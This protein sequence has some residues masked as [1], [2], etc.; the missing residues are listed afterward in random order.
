MVEDHQTSWLTLHNTFAGRVRRGVF[1]LL[2]LTAVAVI[3]GF[4]HIQHQKE[5]YLVAREFSILLEK[6]G[7]PKET[8]EQLHAKKA[9]DR[10]TEPGHSSWSISVPL[11][12]IPKVRTDYKIFLQQNHPDRALRRSSCTWER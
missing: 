4:S 11:Q 2:V 12:R 9:T 7:I 3:D 6:S 8:A 1:L 5:R 10:Q